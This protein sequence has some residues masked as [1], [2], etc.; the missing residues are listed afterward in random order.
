MH[1]LGLIKF[2]REMIGEETYW[3]R[4]EKVESMPDQKQPRHIVS[5][6]EARE[7]GCRAIVASWDYT[8]TVMPAP[9]K[10]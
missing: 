4:G 6:P 5:I 7:V 3:E 10:A 8:R 1:G 2:R 9:R